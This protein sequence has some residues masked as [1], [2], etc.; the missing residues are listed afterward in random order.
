[1]DRSIIIQFGT[2]TN[3][4]SEEGPGS[5]S[6]IAID[7]IYNSSSPLGCQLFL[8]K[9]RISEY[10]KRRPSFVVVTLYYATRPSSQK[11]FYE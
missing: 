11:E 5:E 8:R 1:M 7:M 10:I 6:I 4:P 9:I 3:I 2:N